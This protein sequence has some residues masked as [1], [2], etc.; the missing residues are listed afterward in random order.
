MMVSILMFILGPGLFSGANLLLVSGSVTGDRGISEPSTSST[1]DLLDDPRF[2]GTICNLQRTTTW[3]LERTFH[4]SRRLEKSK[5]QKKPPV[6]ETRLK[7]IPSKSSKNWRI[8]TCFCEK[9]L[10]LDI[11]GGSKKL[12]APTFRAKLDIGGLDWDGF[13]SCWYHS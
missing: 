8:S 5:S 7:S 4:D 13:A 1:V 9:I 2:P 10:S 6:L 12:V 3:S 11:F